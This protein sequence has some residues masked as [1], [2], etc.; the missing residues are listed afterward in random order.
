VSAAPTSAPPAPARRAADTGLTSLMLVGGLLAAAVAAALLTMTGADRYLLQGLPDPGSLTRT[1]M[2]AVRVLAELSSALCVGG[3]LFAAFLVPQRD[4]GLLSVD[5]YRALRGA[6]VA[7]VVWA[8][9]ALLSVPFVVADAVGRPVTAVLDAQVLF[10]LVGAL[11][12]A[13]AWLLTVP[14]ALAVAIATRVVVSWS[15][16]AVLFLVSI[17][18]LLPI[19]M[20]G[21]SSSGGQHDL[22]TNSLLL[23]LVAAALWVGG[24]VALLAHA[25][26]RGAHLGLATARFSVVA[27]VCWIVMAASGVI[28]ALVRLPLSDLLTSG[29]G[30]LVLAKTA[31]LLVLG[32]FGHLHRRQSVPRVRAGSPAALVRFAAVEV[33]VMFLTIGVAAALARTPPPPA[34]GELGRVEA[35]LGYDLD[36]PPTLWR[37]LFDWRFDI[38]FGSAALLL[39]VAYLLGVRSMRA[40]GHRWP[41]GRT[42]AWLLGCLTVLMATSSGI[43]RYAPAMFSVHMQSHMLLS[44]LAP[45]L[46]AMG[47]P[48]TLA[49]RALRP[50]GRGAPPG[51]R[52]WLLAAVHS[53]VA[54]LLTRPVVA[55]AI[56]VGSFYLLYLSGL[57]DAAVERHWAHLA[58]NAHFLLAGYL[59]YWPVVG[60]DPAPARPPHI[61]RLGMVF[62]SLPFHAFFGVILMSMQ[63]VIAAPFYRGLGLPWA[64]DLLADQRLGGGIAW[65]TG[66]LPLVVVM[67]ALL[68][69]W[70]RADDREARRQD[71]K[72]DDGHSDDH[73]AYNAMLRDLARRGRGEQ[74]SSRPSADHRHPRS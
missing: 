66:E 62:A 58:M 15:W 53:P 28:N 9:S 31:G 1:G 41:V 19:A 57:F 40:R 16:T 25:R 64:T 60:I 52:E 74:A 7:A 73:E 69:Q 14:V 72:M 61:V 30:L 22:A 29:Y 42:V 21:H 59:F 23:H 45:V 33:L 44:M 54:R 34:T 35:V 11:P 49:L 63:T 26:R 4:T 65:A 46:L 39:A 50:A 36:G 18:G 47:G 32:L 3:L 13:G 6:G 12:Q 71:R 67:I 27:L 56:F 48:V 51:P 8:M 17:A 2:T 70:A 20:T 37:L 55:L 10:D 24:L 68:A 5:G 43:G 38:V